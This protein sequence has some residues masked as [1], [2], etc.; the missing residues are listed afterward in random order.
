MIGL[1]YF[2]LF[3]KDQRDNKIIAARSADRTSF[4]AQ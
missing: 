4:T 1:G 2:E 3:P